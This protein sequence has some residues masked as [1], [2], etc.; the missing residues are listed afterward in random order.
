MRKIV[1]CL[2]GFVVM[3]GLVK[4]VY[5]REVSLEEAKVDVVLLEDGSMQVS[6]TWT[7]DF[8][9]EFTR[10]SKD[11]PLRR[12]DGQKI[13]MTD[14]SVSVDGIDYQSLSSFDSRRPVGYF[15]NEISQSESNME[16]YLD[17]DDE[18][19]V[20]NISYT[21]SN[22]FVAYDDVIDF[23]HA[24]IGDG[25][26]YDIDRVY[27]TITFPS[28]SSTQDIRVW[29]HGPANGKV[30]IQGAD[31]VQ[32]EC[33]N[34]P[35]NTE[36]SVRLLLPSSLFSMEK[37]SGAQLESIVAE[38]EKYV[39]QEEARQNRLRMQLIA[40]VVVSLI[41]VLGIVWLVLRVRRLT[42]PFETQMAPEFYRD[43]PSH[44]PPSELVDLFNY[45]H[46]R[47]Q[48]DNKFASTLLRFCLLGMLEFE[49]YEKDGFFKDKQVT[50]LI[51]KDIDLDN[52][53]LMDYEKDLY[54]FLRSY[55]S[56]DSKVDMD[57]LKKKMNRSPERAKR[58]LE[59][60]KDG[61]KA[62]LEMDG[63]TD[64]T[65]S[66]HTAK[67][68][69]VSIGIFVLSI[70]GIVLFQAWLL[71]ILAVVSILASVY[72]MTRTRLSQKGENEYVLWKAFEHFLKE[73]T[74]M[75]EK[76]LPELVMWEQYLVYA[77]AL[78]QAET[79]LKRLP[80]VYPDFYES[81]F[82][83]HSYVRFFYF[84][85]MRVPN[86]DLFDGLSHFS[87]DLVTAMNYTANRGGHGG[88]FSSFGG[89]SSSGGGGGSFD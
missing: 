60:F 72:M 31:S 79:V 24:M 8:D 68:A 38:E 76:D 78:G 61:A 29:G 74:L 57:E 49:I 44:M 1:L 26:D 75:N 12:S 58:Q 67:Y 71:I 82:Y 34:L 41:G 33:S 66:Q 39:L 25:W 84:S 36:L 9:G 30:M 73:L 43:L 70:A 19:K 18:T 87:N 53:D 37:M 6:E 48:E 55:A 47:L 69:G 2:V 16:I 15:A 21:L 4:P 42:R 56:K 23:N 11:L 83:Y 10:F 28:V 14:V 5:A 86:L 81:D 20:V 62:L 45:R 63:M 80:E 77:A 59:A 46:D 3:L 65:V 51:F 32:Y 40:S 35:E 50:R 17:A 89:G 22:A 13:D 7:I 85:H 54:T 52:V 88:S 64:H 27:G